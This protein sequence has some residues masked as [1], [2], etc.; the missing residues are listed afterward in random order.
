M[1]RSNHSKKHDLIHQ[2]LYNNQLNFEYLKFTLTS[3][4]TQ[5]IE[6]VGLIFD[7]KERKKNAILAL[8]KM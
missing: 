8:D 4:Y 3:S 1:N 7:A 6:F 2:L 5:C